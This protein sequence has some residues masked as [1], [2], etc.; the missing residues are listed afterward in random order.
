VKQAQVIRFLQHLRAKVPSDQSRTGWVVASCPL[1]PWRHDSGE[2]K[3]PSFAVRQEAGDAFCNCFSCGFHGRQSDLL[4]EMRHLDR[5]A[6]QGGFAFG[7]AFE[8]I[9]E[10]E[11]GLDGIDLDTPDIEEVLFGKKSQPHLFPESWLASFPPWHAVADARA[12]LQQRCVSLAAASLLGLRVDTAQRRVCF[13]VRDFKGR[14]RGLHGRAI[15]AGT[16]PR[17]RMYT[18]Q[19]RNS[20]LIWLGENWVDLD[21]P[22]VVVEGPF[23]LLSVYRCYRNVVSPLFVNPSMAKM[24][25]MADALEWLTLFDRGKGGDLGRARV[26]RKLPDQL[27]RHAWPPK[28]RKDPGEMTMEEVGELL[29]DHVQLDAILGN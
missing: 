27:V 2:D 6:P 28:H 19:G 8:L 5:Q 1:A 15:D 26:S 29:Q 16:T 20:P 12:Y 21:R 7:R 25:R 22:I 24:R 9:T 23:D 11:D 14:L 18:H 10:A 17:Y 3:H 13:P 4:L